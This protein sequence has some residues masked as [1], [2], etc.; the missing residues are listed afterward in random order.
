M[1]H[2]EDPMCVGPMIEVCTNFG[3]GKCGADTGMAHTTG[4]L[5][6]AHPKELE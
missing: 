4:E 5:V 1:L 6:R 3:M 2:A